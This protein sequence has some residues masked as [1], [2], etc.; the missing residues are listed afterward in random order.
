MAILN[1]NVEVNGVTF[2][3]YEIKSGFFREKKKYNEEIA[4]YEGYVDCIVT[5]MGFT[6]P[7]YANEWTK[8]VI[9]DTKTVTLEFKKSES[10]NLDL[11]TI[12][13]MTYQRMFELDGFENA[14]IEQ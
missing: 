3:Y 2:T 5:V 10:L 4:D 1:T 7:K 13:G 8:T 14:T 11:K 6:D 9:K 12:Y